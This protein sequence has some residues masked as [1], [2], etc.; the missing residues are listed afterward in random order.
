MKRDPSPQVEIRDVASGL[1]IWR[2]EHR[3]RAL[4]F[5]CLVATR[6]KTA[7]LLMLVLSACQHSRPSAA[8]SPATAPA[9]TEAL[10][11]QWVEVTAPG[12]GIMEAAVA[13]PPGDGPFPA[14]ILLHGRHGFGHQY[15][16]LAQELARGGLLAVAACWFS[17]GDG[18]GSRFVTPIAC[19]NGPPMPGGGSPEALAI[20]R[21]LVQATRTL[22][23]V[24]ADRVGLFGHS[25][26]GGATLNYVLNMSDVQ[27]AII[28]SGGYPTR[29]VER[30]DQI[31]APIL[32]L[33]GQAD[34]PDDGGSEVTNVQMARNF[35]AALRRFGK[36]VEAVYYPMGG[37]NS[38]FSSS[39]QHADEVQR[40]IAFLHRHLDN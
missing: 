11:V 1:W 23:S 22:P 7:A 19:P 36:P 28:D 25:R 31:K 29:L 5:G 27:A 38:I 39:T 14:V 20:V 35:E 32:M 15:V 18:P 24:R 2:L 3:L 40:M 30:A 12:L 33:H 10:A 34:S 21:A 6:T 8:V 9:G 4:T 37:H 17:R 13:R 26:G 16:Q